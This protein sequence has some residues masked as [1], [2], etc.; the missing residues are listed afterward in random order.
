MDYGTF[1]KFVYKAGFEIR[2]FAGLLGMN[3]RSISNYSGE[4]AIPEHL[5]LIVLLMDELEHRN[6]NIRDIV[7]KLD[8]M[9]RKKRKAHSGGFNGTQR[10]KMG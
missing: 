9:G 7:A 1:K 8:G 5:A 4:E 2:E 3:H 10:K 6:V